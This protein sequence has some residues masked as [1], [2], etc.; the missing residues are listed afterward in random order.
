M[1]TVDNK[2]VIELNIKIMSDVYYCKQDTFISNI[3]FHV[4]FYV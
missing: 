2:V 3:V 1:A 4:F